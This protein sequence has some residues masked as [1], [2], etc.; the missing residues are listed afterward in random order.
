M[1]F[2]KRKAV[3]LADMNSPAPDK[4]PKGNID[5]PI[6]P[7]LA[8]IN[9][10][11]SYFTTSSCSGRISILSQ[12]NAAVASS[13]KKAKGGSWVLI[14]HDP[15]KPDSVVD[16]LFNTSLSPEDPVYDSSLVLRF[17]PLIIAI[18]CIDVSSAQSLVSLAISCG[19]RESGITNV[20]KRV[21]VAIRCSIRME[22]PLGDA[23]KLMV[24]PEYVKFLIG[25]AN[26]KMDSNQRRTDNFHRALLDKGFGGS[27]APESDC[28]INVSDH[29][30]VSQTGVLG[31]LDSGLCMDQIEIS[32]ESV[33][34]LFI[35]GHTACTLS[36]VDNKL[37]YIFGGFGGIG[38]HSRRNDC[39]VL[40]PLNGKLDSINCE[41]AP[42][43]LLG[44]SSCMI[45]DLMFVIGGRADPVNILNDVW[46]LDS[47][48][49]KWN[50]LQVSANTF[51]PRHRHASVSVDS[52]I[53]VFG[54]LV[55]DTVSSEL[56]FLDTISLEWYEIPNEGGE[57]PCP[58]H[59]HSLVANGSQ[60]FMF[61][62]Y[63]GEKAL[64]ELYSFDTQTRKWKNENEIIG[65]YPY[66]RF[67]HLMFVYK[68]YIGILGGCPI[69]QRYQEL[70]LL[71]LKNREWRHVRLNSIGQELFVRSTVN[72]VGDDLIMIGGG[73]ACYAF[74]TKFSQP[75]KLS[76]LPLISSNKIQVEEK[77]MQADDDI[78]L[79]MVS[80]LQLER[81]H[82]KLGKDILKEFGWLDSARKVYSN[83][84]GINICFPVT[85]T[86]CSL[87]LKKENQSEDILQED[88][89]IQNLSCSKALD[90]LKACGGKKIIDQF[91]ERRKIPTPPSEIMR[92]A[93]RV[94][95][96]REGLPLELLEELPT[97]WER[98]GDIVVLPV[99]CFKNTV[100]DSLG[101]EIWPIVADSLGTNRLAKQG[102]IA[103]TGTRDSKLEI[104]FGDGG[105]WVDHRE[106]GITYSF[107]ATKCMFSWGNL[108]EK[109]RVGRFDCREETVVDLFAG[110]GYF[111]LPFLVRANA[112]FVYACEWNPHAIEALKRN[113]RINSVD[114]RCIVLEGD[115]TIMAPK[116]IADRVSLGL[117]PTSE[118]SWITAVRALRSQGGILHVHGT[119]KDVEEVSWTEHVKK[120]ISEIAASE[121]YDWDVSVQHV[122]RVKWYAPHI[123]HLVV[124][125]RCSQIHRCD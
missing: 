31:S 64:G 57:W 40:D 115:N 38:R 56:Y 124:D 32:G 93:I 14:S 39:L 58:R 83:E 18:E 78:V 48:T 79:Q 42:C 104:V 75:M 44:H 85:E 77:Q 53:Y 101:K 54:G 37:V 21:I 114:D 50:L 68:N 30:E 91:A 92:E 106:N 49:N 76:L 99:T 45:D 71:D 62:G 7:L 9:S 25:I 81:Q 122:E 120:S 13:K 29:G 4:S 98:L 46:V 63:D 19:F 95:L 105:G 60:L 6:I 84:K 1:D 113:L 34:K 70:S 88:N 118:G 89:T 55:N 23:G 36:N 94:V 87:Y 67:S 10:H 12:P 52:K 16:L 59:S 123:R 51:S 24:S 97:R 86:F 109:L 28:Q 22:V 73:A 26:E 33:E 110:I 66:P 125:I 15:V 96:E 116:G 121:G 17:E 74:G 108:S 61:G 69:R 82:A 11:S 5:A 47:K 8:A 27:E 112:K 102:S 2:E 43:P 41:Q 111:V 65:R 100:W 103:P 35:W 20:S 3:A 117:L 80:S 72:V 90:L 107:D 119:V